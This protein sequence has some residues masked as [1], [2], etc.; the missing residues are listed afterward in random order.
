M[1]YIAVCLDTRKGE[2]GK[3]KVNA[4]KNKE[5]TVGMAKKG[6]TICYKGV[7]GY[8]KWRI[9]VNFAISQ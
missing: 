5:D 2:K 1:S 3:E 9:N 4:E 6:G 7:L 8:Y